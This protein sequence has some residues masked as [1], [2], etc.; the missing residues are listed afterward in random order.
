MRLKG[1]LSV[2]VAALALVVAACGSSNDGGS[3]S[4][5]SNTAA[6]SSTVAGASGASTAKAAVDKL[7]QPPQPIKLQPLSKRPAAGKSVAL[8]SCPVPG[9]KLAESSVIP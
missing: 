2:A 6:S 3:K 4:S 8:V 1:L 5:K 7:L 9:C